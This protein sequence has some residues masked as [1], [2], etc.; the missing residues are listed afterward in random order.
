MVTLE[1]QGRAVRIS[2]EQVARARD[3]AAAESGRSLPLRDLAL[4]LDLALT[5]QRVIVLR[6]GEARELLQ[7]ADED[8][9]LADLAEALRAGDDEA[10]A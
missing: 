10:A 3:L 1:I 5:V 8:P 7:L 6:R 2:R 4:V 9:S